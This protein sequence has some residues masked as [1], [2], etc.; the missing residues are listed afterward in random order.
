MHYRAELHRCLDSAD[1]SAGTLQGDSVRG[2]ITEYRCKYIYPL[3]LRSR[4]DEGGPFYILMKIDGG[5]KNG[6]GCN[7]LPSV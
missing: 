4:R 3:S 2:Q 1:Q 6:K 7:L 5:I